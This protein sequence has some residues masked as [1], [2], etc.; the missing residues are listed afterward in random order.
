MKKYLLFA[1]TIL[2]L[3]SCYKEPI[4][5]YIEWTTFYSSS[6]NHYSLISATPCSYI[7]FPTKC[8]GKKYTTGLGGTEKKTDH[9]QTT[10]YK[11]YFY[12]QGKLK[13]VVRYLFKGKYCGG[14]VIES[15][16]GAPVEF[17]FECVVKP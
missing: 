4:D 2:F 13:G 10:N 7:P 5:V 12:L 15:N 3:T 9:Y 1:L 17:N 16:G 11:N 6:D 8:G 14:G